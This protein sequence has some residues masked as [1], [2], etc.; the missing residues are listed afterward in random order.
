[1]LTINDTLFDVS[2]ARL[3]AGART[4]S[5]WRLEQMHRLTERPIFLVGIYRSGTT[6]ARYVLDSHSRITCP[7]ETAFMAGLAD[8]AIGRKISQRFRQHGL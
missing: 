2:I 4:F 5:F 3:S 7:P 1:M 8:L 6:L